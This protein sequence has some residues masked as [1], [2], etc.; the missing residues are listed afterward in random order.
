MGACNFSTQT[1]SL[2][3]G[4]VPTGDGEGKHWNVFR[5]CALCTGE[6]WL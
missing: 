5:L 6:R 4:I 1:K 3:V 2:T